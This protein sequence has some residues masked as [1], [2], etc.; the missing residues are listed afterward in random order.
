MIAVMRYK[1]KTL[2]QLWRMKIMDEL[3]MEFTNYGSS[4]IGFATTGSAGIDLPSNEKVHIAQGRTRFMKTGIAVHI[5]DGY[6]GV[7]MSRSGL[8]SKHGIVVAQGV[9]LIDSDYRG[10]LIVPLY[11]RSVHAKTIVIGDRIAQ[12]VIIPVAQPTLLQVNS[13]EITD[14]GT[15][16]FG[17]TGE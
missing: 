3:R 2:T 10:E 8:G 16:G 6:A 1:I 15:G 14:R 11:N 17:S 9:G 13:L 12:L 4:D 7:I 5:P